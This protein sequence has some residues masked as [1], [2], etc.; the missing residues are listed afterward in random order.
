MIRLV[1]RHFV[2]TQAELKKPAKTATVL[3]HKNV[4]NMLMTLG[5]SFAASLLIF[6]S[7]MAYYFIAKITPFD[8]YN[9]DFLLILTIV[10][11]ALVL[12]VIIIDLVALTVA[13][14][15]VW[16]KQ[17]ALWGTATLAATVLWLIVYLVLIL[18][19]LLFFAQ[20]RTYP[21]DLVPL[22]GGPS[23]EIP[24]TR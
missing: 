3:A 8:Y 1:I 11:F 14:I 10:K 12:L 2:L 23:Q 5:V 13:V 4:S 19:I 21:S 22:Y 16:K 15:Y 24:P 20:N 7:W 17:G 6:F 9:Y 18:V